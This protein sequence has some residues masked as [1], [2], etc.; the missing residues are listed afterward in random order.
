M[1]TTSGLLRQIFGDYRRLILAL[2]VVAIV[3]M[4][5]DALVI[6]PL[7]LK[8][9]ASERR[10][11]TVTE[12]L[13]AARKDSDAVHATLAR[14]GQAEADLT[15]FYK[16]VL[17]PDV[18]GARRLTYARLAAMASEHNLTIV[19]RSYSL[20]DSYKGRLRRLQIEMS[21][22]GEY[23]D[24]RDFVY[25][26]ETAPEF[27]VIENVGVSEGA[28]AQSGLTVALRLATYFRAADDGR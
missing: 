8:V 3:N 27:V 4:A 7:S 20:D 14:T 1:R 13:R 18:S 22:N 25:A 28:R 23:P 6:Y 12:Q 24:L 11:T 9:S 16:N 10:A 19:A 17:P 5:I 26:V 2:V 15:T 21:I